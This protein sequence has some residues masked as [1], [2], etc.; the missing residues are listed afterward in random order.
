MFIRAS[1]PTAIINSC[2]IQAE[3]KK[4][5]E[6]VL[7]VYDTPNSPSNMTLFSFLSAY[8]HIDRYQPVAGGSYIETPEFLADKKCI[9]NVDNSVAE[10]KQGMDECFRFATLSSVKKPKKDAQRVSKY[11]TEEYKDLLDFTDIPSPTPC[12]A[13]VFKKFEKN[14]PTFSLNV[15]SFPTNGKSLSS[16]RPVYVSPHEDRI[17][18]SIMTIYKIGDK[19]KRHYVSI[20]NFSRLMCDGSTDAHATCPRCLYTF[21]G[22]TIKKDGSVITP[23]MR[24]TSH[25]VLCKGI[26]G[27]GCQKTEYPKPGTIKQFEAFHKMHMVPYAI[28]LDFESTLVNTAVQKGEKSELVSEHVANSFCFIVIGPDGKEVKE[29]KRFYRGEEVQLEVSIEK[30]CRCYHS[31]WKE[32]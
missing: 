18:L 21:K 24:L 16:L 23:D 31:Q 9:V 32:L 4:Q 15:F 26:N 17:L 10:K 28:Y 12:F 6:E 3:L 1:N 5:Y 25:A 20:S 19:A 11:Q 13:S 8:I 14:N 30:E 2:D 27:G 22:L 7:N 29:M